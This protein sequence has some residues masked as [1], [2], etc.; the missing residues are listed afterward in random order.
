MKK[1]PMCLLAA[2]LVLVIYICGSTGL[3]WIWR[4]ARGSLLDSLARERVKARAAGTVEKREVNTY[5]TYLYL[6]NASLT[7]ESKQYPIRK[8][9]CETD[10]GE[11]FFTGQQV[12]L[13]GTLALAEEPGNP[14]EFNRLRYERARKI[15]YHLEDTRVLEKS[16]GSSPF[17]GYLESSRNFCS[18]LLKKIFPRK[19]AGILGAMILGEKSGV[20]SQIRE[21][22]Q[23]AGI[24]HVMA[25]SGL[26]IT[27]LGMGIWKLLG[28]LGIP[29]FVSAAISIGTLALYGLWIGSGASALRAIIMFAA[30]L[31]A[32]LTG[33]TYDLP[34]GLS[35]AAVLLLLDNPD[36][37]FD[38]GFQLSFTAVLGVG[39]AAPGLKSDRTAGE[40][41][42]KK[43]GKQDGKR[44]GKGWRMIEWIL[45]I[46][47]AAEPGVVLWFTTLPVVLETF[48]QVSLIG[49]AV[50]LLVIP[51]VQVVL[52]SGILAMAVG[53]VHLGLGSMAGIP[54]YAVLRLYELLGSLSERLPLAMWTPGQPGILRCVCYYLLGAAIL[55][56]AV[57][58]KR[59]QRE[60]GHVKTEHK[61]DC[62]KTSVQS[63][64]GKF[65][66]RKAIYESWILPGPGMRTAVRAG[67]IFCMLLL[68]GVH[69]RKGMQVTMIDVGQGDA[70]LTGADGC[71]TLIDG[72]SSSRSGI[73]TYVIWPYLKSQG[74]TGLEA[75]F[76]THS[77]ADHVNGIHELLEL[78]GK[79]SLRI[80]YLFMPDWMK[81][82][83]EG[84]KL[85]KTGEAAGC[86]C[87]YLG[88]G[89]RIWQKNAEITVLHP[90][91]GETWEDPNRGSLVF[92]WEYR[93]VRGL[94]T[95]DLPEEEEKR[96]LQELQVC[97]FLKVGHHGSDGSSSREFLEAADPSLA[98]ISCGLNNRYGHPGSGTMERLGERDCAV[99][100]TDTMGAVTLRYAGRGLEI[101]WF[102][103]R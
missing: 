41:S 36:L 96:L 76:V 54:A 83:P 48:S 7:I 19:E 21:W 56:E 1:R 73:G 5:T 62:R 37:L 22:Y 14:G 30:V 17:S 57:Y 45:R 24:S 8:I 29:A 49:I 89:D 53:A 10:P 99:L 32:R 18:N 103:D 59:R 101:S 51:L 70:I 82:D 66:I 55:W 50:N 13:E 79:G 77:D 44:S 67:M 97:D 92:L 87:V 84:E 65:S 26:H 11:K 38:S 15:D 90:G 16:E 75:V 86:V 100:R 80:Q 6:K 58:R 47:D 85:Q 88:T 43:S 98:L 25:I 91:K 94:F 27:L 95:G 40:K 35:L 4:G 69:S 31:G 78:A 28:V 39:V 68:M 63:G 93:D 34:S 33:R 64:R 42:E 74:I 46:R 60:G 102:R 2:V 72:G 61:A 20:D 52:I 3:S 12:C 71:W 81:D 23:Y 9:K